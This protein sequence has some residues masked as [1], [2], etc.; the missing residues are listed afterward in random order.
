MIE[1][2][3]KKNLFGEEEEGMEKKNRK[4]EIKIEKEF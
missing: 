2:K 3:I 4:K 1:Q